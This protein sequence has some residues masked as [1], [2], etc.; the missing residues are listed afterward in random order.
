MYISFSGLSPRGEHLLM[1]CLNFKYVDSF[2]LWLRFSWPVL[3]MCTPSPIGYT[4]DI[5]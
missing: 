5:C 4:E 1:S 2:F 3:S